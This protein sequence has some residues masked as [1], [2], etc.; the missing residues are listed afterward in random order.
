MPGLENRPSTGVEAWENTRAVD[1]CA[2]AGVGAKLPIMQMPLLCARRKPGCGEPD[3]S[4]VLI[5]VCGVSFLL[6]IQPPT[7]AKARAIASTIKA[8]GNNKRG[9]PRRGWA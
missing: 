7:Q 2:A 6:P 4:A 5:M 1:N 8:I 9:E 3:A